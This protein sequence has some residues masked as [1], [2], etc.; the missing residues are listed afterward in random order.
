[1]VVLVDGD[2]GVLVQILNGSVASSLKQH[3]TLI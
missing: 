2:G 3:I 1:M